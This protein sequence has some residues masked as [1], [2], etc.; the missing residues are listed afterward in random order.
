MKLVLKSAGLDVVG[1]ARGEES[2]VKASKI[3]PD[4]IPLDLMMP[5]MDGWQTYENLRKI[6][7]A[8]FVFVSERTDKFAIVHGQDLG[9]DEYVTK[10]SRPSELIAR[11]QRM[12]RATDWRARLVS[13]EKTMAAP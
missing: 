10:P 8:L 12:A 2:M 13:S 1:A 9:A 4:I 3:Y 11:V 5:S 7:D 6:T